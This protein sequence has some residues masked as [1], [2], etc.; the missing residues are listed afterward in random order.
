MMPFGG[1]SVE[2]SR[3]LSLASIRVYA[4][5]QVQPGARPPPP[6]AFTVDV[7]WNEETMAVLGSKPMVHCAE[8][9]GRPP[10]VR[11]SWWRSS[12]VQTGR[13]V[14]IAATADAPAVG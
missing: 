12:C 13:P 3:E 11:R 5:M 6:P 1:V 4:P 9:G 7:S 2:M 8:A 10:R 14:T